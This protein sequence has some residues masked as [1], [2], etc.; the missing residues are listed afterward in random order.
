MHAKIA[1]GSRVTAHLRITLTDGT[2]AEST[3][4][5]SPLE[6]V[7]GSGELHRNLEQLFVD[8]SEGETRHFDRPA[9]RAFGI[10]HE[11]FVQ[12]LALEQFSASNP[13]EKGQVIEFTQP[14]G[15][16]IA[17]TVLNVEDQSVVVDFNPPLAGRDLRVEIEILKVTSGT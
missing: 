7:V 15:T 4:E 6:F 1:A 12:T 10:P 9:E 11:E 16:P 8:L 14:D 5:G 3:F 2:I 13:P 17:G